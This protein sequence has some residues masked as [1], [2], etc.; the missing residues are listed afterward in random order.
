MTSSTLTTT[1]ILHLC[2]SKD[3]A[4]Q[5]LQYLHSFDRFVLGASS[6][7]TRDD[8]STRTQQEERSIQID[9]TVIYAVSS[10]KHKRAYQQLERM[11]PLIQWRM[12]TNRA[13]AG[14]D[15]DGDENDDNK[16]SPRGRSF[17]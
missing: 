5:L 2:V 11:W 8:T 13:A 17:A 6:G 16:E 15:D 14:I 10:D 9:T 12:E 3:R 1:R 4:F 7:S